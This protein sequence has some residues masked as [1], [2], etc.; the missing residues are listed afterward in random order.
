MSKLDTQVFEK[1]LGFAPA[2]KTVPVKEIISAVEAGLSKETNTEMANVTRS[3][4]SSLIAKAKKKPV[5]DN[6]TTE[7]RHALRSLQKDQTL[8]SFRQIR[9]TE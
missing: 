8:R 5:R 1:G 3:K 2:P 4:V 7:E 9:G 6:M